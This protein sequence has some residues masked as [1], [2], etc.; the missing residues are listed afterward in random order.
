MIGVWLTLIVVAPS[1]G[2]LS[3][4]LVKLGDG[5]LGLAVACDVVQLG[6]WALCIVS[7]WLLLVDSTAIVSCVEGL[8]TCV[9]AGDC[10]GEGHVWLAVVVVGVAVCSVHFGSERARCNSLRRQATRFRI[11]VHPL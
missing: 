6:G 4:M 9:L 10:Q 7:K 8:I 1:F 2:A 3:G 5:A 11:T